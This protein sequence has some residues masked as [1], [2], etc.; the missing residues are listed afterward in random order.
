MKK[1]LSLQDFT[2][3]STIIYKGKLLDFANIVLSLNRYN[4]FQVKYQ[5]A[6]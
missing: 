2:V 4:L 6:F 5:Q 3:A 1:K